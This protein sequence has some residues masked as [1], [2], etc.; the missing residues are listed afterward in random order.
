MQIV[1]ATSP[2][3]IKIPW[4]KGQ[5]GQ[6]L[7]LDEFFLDRKNPGLESC[8]ISLTTTPNGAGIMIAEGE[9]ALFI[10]VTMLVLRMR[11][12]KI[13]VATTIVTQ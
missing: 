13:A 9:N 5:F 4:K 6:V 10:P 11:E 7:V 1:S 2:I 3:P 12:Q 8:Q